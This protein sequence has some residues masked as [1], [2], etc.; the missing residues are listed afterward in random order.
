MELTREKQ[1]YTTTTLKQN[2]EYYKEVVSL[3]EEA[4]GYSERNRFDIDFAPLMDRE[5]WANLHLIIDVEKNM[6]I[7][8]VGVCI[9]NMGKGQKTES[10]PV[11]FIGGVAVHK[12][13]RKQGH[14]SSLMK[15][16]VEIHREQVSLLL[17]WSEQTE[18]Y[19]KFGFKPVFGQMVNLSD[20]NTH[21]ELVSLGYIKAR[22]KDLDEDQKSQIQALFVGSVQQ[23]YF[24]TKRS[25]KDWS[26]IENISSTSLYLKQN[27]DGKISTYI[28]VGKGQ[29][30]QGAIH[31]VAY[32]PETKNQLIKDIKGLTCW[33]PE[34]IAEEFDNPQ[35]NYMALGMIG[36]THMFSNLVRQASSG[37]VKLGWVRNGSASISFDGESYIFTLPDLFEHLFGPFPAT[38]LREIVSP[39]FISGWDSV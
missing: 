22:Y 2:P 20:K 6:P 26:I 8:H 36:D 11:A 3:I 32:L 17:L 16:V 23:K 37:R 33:L 10:V 14:F 1:A 27:N 35:I 7:A 19:Y 28:A 13:Y 9:R 34:Y 24:T 4:L 21:D 5:N 12:N 29:D 30:L 31:E 15:K 39:F 18:L 38:E 25:P